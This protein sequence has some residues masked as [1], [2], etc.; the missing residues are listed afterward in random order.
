MDRETFLLAVSCVIGAHDQACT[1][2]RPWCRGGF[3]PALS[4]AEGI[5]MASGGA[6]CKRASDKAMWPS[7][8][9]PYSP[10]FPAWRERTR[11][12]RPAAHLWPLKAA[13]QP[14]LTHFSGP[15]AAPSQPIDTLPWPVCVSTRRGRARWFQPSADYGSC[16]AKPLDDD[17][18]TRGLRRSRRGLSTPCPFLA[19]R[20]Y[21]LTPP[22]AL[23]EACSGV[24]PAAKGFLDASKQALWAE[25]HVI[26]GV[27]PPRARMQSAH[28]QT[29]PKHPL[30]QCGNNRLYSA[31]EG[32][33]HR[34]G[35]EAHEGAHN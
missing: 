3:A 10:C 18:F 34:R 7:C 23:V 19:V 15:A 12:V 30:H 8:R 17:G 29:R 33:R 28:P 16:A 21:N 35:R 13:L 5:T 25:R 1:A 31:W 27:T 14:R 4:E 32:T 24:V 20:P 9:P 2:H 22:A 11:L 6:S 26:T